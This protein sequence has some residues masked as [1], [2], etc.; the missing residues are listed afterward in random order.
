MP[1]IV[2]TAASK[3]HYLNFLFYW[4]SNLLNKKRRSMQSCRNTV[5]NDT[6]GALSATK[7]ISTGFKLILLIKPNNALIIRKLLTIVRL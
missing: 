6:L 1:T 2:I 7:A 3:N 4:Q 5:L